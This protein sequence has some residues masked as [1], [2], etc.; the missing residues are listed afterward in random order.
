MTIPYLIE[1]AKNRLHYYQQQ[2]L[3]YT[4]VGD[5]E[6]IAKFQELADETNLTISRLET[7]L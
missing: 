6:N 7:L 1:Q 5:I 4:S 2:V 3:Y